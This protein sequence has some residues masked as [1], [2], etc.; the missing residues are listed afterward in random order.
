[1]PNKPPD[2]SAG[3]L[4]VIAHAGPM[5]AQLNAE[6]WA[7]TY[8]V[9]DPKNGEAILIDP[10]HGNE[11]HDV[12]WLE[13]HGLSCTM[14]VN[15]HTHADH[16]TSS[17]VLAESLGVDYVMHEATSVP[18]ANRL[19]S[20]GDLL[21]A[22]DV[23]LR[24]MH[25]P[26]HTLDSM[27]LVGHG[28]LITGDFLFGGP[29]GVGRDD[30]PGGDLG[31][32]WNSIS[33]LKDLDPSLLVLSGHEPPGAPIWTLGETLQMSAPLR[34]STFDE[35]EA[36]QRDEWVRLGK[37]SKIDTALPANLSCELP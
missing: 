36:W 35:Y 37:V 22:G 13:H 28:L 8:V 25:T 16:I 17:F 19:V 7:R 5:W 21:S 24:V 31:A 18:K 26:G 27:T 2:V 23:S 30:L 10:V 4:Q 32:H 9:A 1:M 11:N 29:G 33:H 3:H 20:D 6:G 15:T 14:L 12:E 34:C